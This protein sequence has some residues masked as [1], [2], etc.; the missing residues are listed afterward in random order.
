[1]H[2]EMFL[3]SDTDILLTYF[4]SHKKAIAK[5]VEQYKK[6]NESTIKKEINCQMAS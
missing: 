5:S 4:K 2:L 6:M 1:M 3:K